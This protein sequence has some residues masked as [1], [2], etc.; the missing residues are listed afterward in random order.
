MLR[1]ELTDEQWE[2][3]ADVFPPPPA[4]GRPPRDRRTM[5]DGIL[6]ILRTGAPWRDL[7][8]E[9]GPW[10]TVYGLFNTW[11]ATGLLDEILNRLRT[12]HV[13]RGM[14][15]DQL[16]CVDGTVVRAH[17]CA[18]GGAAAVAWSAAQ[19]PLAVNTASGVSRLNLPSRHSRCDPSSTRFCASISRRPSLRPRSSKSSTAMSREGRLFSF[20]H[21]IEASK[22]FPVES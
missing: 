3:I 11:N 4:T 9:F 7:P 22:V 16:W 6:W 21:D 14:H 5:V 18:S 17:R 10:E 13:D 19:L 12:M 1:H 15:D 20:Q 8:K 2:L